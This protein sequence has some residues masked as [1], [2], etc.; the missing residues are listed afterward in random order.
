[1]PLIPTHW[2]NRDNH[3]SMSLRLARS[4][5]EFQ[6]NETLIQTKYIYSG[7]GLRTTTNIDL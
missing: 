5:N 6:A 7:K 4:I 1:M 3:I 2:G